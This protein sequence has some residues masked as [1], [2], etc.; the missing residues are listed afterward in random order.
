MT[1]NEL[2]AK[3]AEVAGMQKSE[4]LRAVEGMMQVMGD[5]FSQAENI[6][7][8]GFGTFRVVMRQAKS[9]RNITRNTEVIIPAHRAVKFI[10]C[11]TLKEKVRKGGKC[12]GNRRR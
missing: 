9:G 7:L 6:Y 2:A 12:A 10:P 11:P 3:V 4:A 5:T 1:K 8:R